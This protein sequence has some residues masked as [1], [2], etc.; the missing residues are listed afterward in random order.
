[1][2]RASDDFDL[3]IVNVPFLTSKSCLLVWLRRCICIPIYTIFYD[4]S[5]DGHIE[6]IDPKIQCFRYL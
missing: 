2:Y 5:Y 3:I 1:M 4:V 6:M